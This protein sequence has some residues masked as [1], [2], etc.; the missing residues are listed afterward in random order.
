MTCPD[1]QGWSAPVKQSRGDLSTSHHQQPEKTWIMNLCCFNFNFWCFSFQVLRSPWPFGTESQ[2]LL[3]EPPGDIPGLGSI[4]ADTIKGMAGF[5]SMAQGIFTPFGDILGDGW[6]VLPCLGAERRVTHGGRALSPGVVG[7]PNPSRCVSN[8]LRFGSFSWVCT[9]ICTLL[10]I[11][12]LAT[13]TRMC[14]CICIIYVIFIYTYTFCLYVERH[15]CMLQGWQRLL[16]LSQESWRS[17][18]I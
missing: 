14:V 12:P 5:G 13:Y 6:W 2:T 1:P 10:N 7:S 8:Y 11:R 4:S 16:Y 15:M 17:I 18:I 9:H 3:L